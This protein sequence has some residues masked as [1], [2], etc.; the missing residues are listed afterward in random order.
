MSWIEYSQQD[1]IPFPLPLMECKTSREVCKITVGNATF[2][3]LIE[4]MDGTEC[5][6]NIHGRPGVCKEVDRRAMQEI[7]E[8][9]ETSLPSS[10]GSSSVIKKNT[11]QNSAGDETWGNFVRTSQNMR[12]C[13]LGDFAQSEHERSQGSK[14]DWKW[15]GEMPNEANE[16]EKGH[17][18]FTSPMSNGKRRRKSVP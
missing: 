2:G 15:V 6:E 14:E 7:P 16:A 10:P 13:R 9:C 11:E 4:Q 8:V 12:L 17:E 1:D 5:G 3:G 18:L